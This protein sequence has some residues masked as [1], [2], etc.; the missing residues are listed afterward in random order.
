MPDLRARD[1]RPAPRTKAFGPR[2]ALALALALAVAVLAP[3][4]RADVFILHGGDRITGKSVLEGKRS[5]KVQ[6]PFGVLTIPRDKVD[7][8]VRPDGTEQPVNPEPV[9]T[10]ATLP[11]SRRAR[12][13]LIITGK[14]F[15]QAWDPKGRPDPTLR[16]EVSLD[17]EVVATYV[18]AK[19]DPDIPG[20]LVNAFSFASE[21][22]TVITGENALV[23]PPEPRPGRIALKIDVP[24]S[25]AP[26]RLRIAYQASEGP[27]EEKAWRDLATGAT[28]VEL[29]ATAPTFV[30]VSQDRG[31]M[32]FGG[33]PRK[34]MKYV[35]TF[36]VELSPEHGPEHDE[37][38]PPLTP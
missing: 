11:P 38:A 1:M 28:D 13:I 12:L 7:H 15:W 16:L 25:E 31:R 34:R 30:R 3:A 2:V 36:K 27:A 9:A 37:A 4:V 32:E 20:A 23:L 22:V 35:E 18:D 5:F 14:T 33:F 29:R 10:V 8:I 24:A 21:D 26:R 6:T 17:E 19:T